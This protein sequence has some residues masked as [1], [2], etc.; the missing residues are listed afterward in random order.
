MTQAIPHLSISAHRHPPLDQSEDVGLGAMMTTQ[1][2]RWL[3]VVPPARPPWT[4]GS[5]E[6]GNGSQMTSSWPLL[7]RRCPAS[8]YG[9]GKLVVARELGCCAGNSLSDLLMTG[10]I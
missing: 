4:S 1:S 2:P 8:P 10:K 3:V 6:S 5:A 7:L 9:G